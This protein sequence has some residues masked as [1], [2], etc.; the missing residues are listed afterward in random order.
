MTNYRQTMTQ[1]LEFMHIMN[2]F[3]INE[4]ELT[5]TE[6]KRREEIAQDM[7]DADFKS[8]YGDR[9]KEVKMAVATKQ[10]K[11]EDGDGPLSTVD[12]A[13]K[14]DIYHKTFSDAMQHSYK[15]AKKMYGITVDPKE[16]DQKV[17]AGPKKPS[18]GKTNRYQLKGDKGTIQVQVANLDN[19]KYE[20]NMYKEEVELDEDNMD[21]LRK[22][23][24]G[25]MQTIKFKDGKQ[26][27]DSFS[28]SGIMQVYDK[29][30]S[31]NKKAMEN[32]INKGTVSQV[33]KLQSLA[34]KQA[35]EEIKIE[36][37]FT[38]KDFDDKEDNN[39]HT[40]NAVEL[41]K[42]FGDNYEKRQVAQIQKDH[43]KNRSISAK[44][45]KVRDALI[46]KYLSKL[47]E[48]L[49]EKVRYSA[50]T[51]DGNTFQ[52][53]DRDTK[54]M[55]GKQDDYKMVVVD[56]KGKVV[57]DCGA[58]VTVDGA[59]MFAK[60][61]KIIED[62]DLDE[63]KKKTPVFK[64]TPAQIKKQM[65]DYK[66]KHDKLKIGEEDLDE[67]GP[68]LWANIHKKR[69][70]GRPMRKKGEKGAP[71]DAAIKRSQEEVDLDE[72]KETAQYTDGKQ[73]KITVTVDNMRKVNIDTVI[74]KNLRPGWKKV[75][76]KSGGVGRSI[77]DEVDLEEATEKDILNALKKERIGGY[78]S[79]GKLYVAQR[80]LETVRDLLRDMKLK[81]MPKLVG[82]ELSEFIKLGESG[83]ST[84]HQ[85]IK[86][87]KS[88]KEIA[89]LMKVDAKTIEKL[90][91]GF[92]EHQ[93]SVPHKHPHDSGDPKDQYD[94][95]EERQQSESARSDAMKSMRRSGEF[96]DKDDVDITAT[97]DDVK[98]ASKNIIMQMRKAQ[99]L[100]GR[101]AVE[102]LDR[103]KVKVP[104]KI[105]VAVQQKYNSLRRPAEKQKFQEKVAKSYKGMLSALKE[106]LEEGTWKVPETRI[107]QMALRKALRKPIKAKDAEKVM[108]PHIGDD[109]LYD[110]FYELEKDD[111]NQDVRPLIRNRMK[112]LGIKEETVLD[113]I[114]IK[115]QERK[116]G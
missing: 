94:D 35:K 71:T 96:S 64:G 103:K 92:K 44:D 76:K 98:A 59:V 16:I 65:K 49:D 19:K 87:G 113:R 34:M 61:K 73:E 85:H 51:K 24:K 21:L 15:A 2:E 33:L 99:S 22:A 82:E 27:M 54:G 70:E 93:T 50:K 56:K 107:D 90:M 105:A 18:A 43:N 42:M 109:S 106:A 101:F 7:D 26:K 9:W 81:V 97:D 41:V 6:K 84:L 45:Q 69:K 62:V 8:R 28:A 52:V 20:L 110:E 48:N 46:N 104:A 100:N 58:H 38:K 67:K 88:A 47:K 37:K 95:E 1:T 39:D 11:K 83:M 77:Y 17:A 57:K 36:E 68:G 86:D 53:I 114:A 5:D 63:Q 14:Y 116:N 25:A 10:A 23:A 102:F 72:K 3:R 60:N 4:R 40:Q 91:K 13:T 79:G 78:F 29:L 12:E 111:P 32:I 115:I 74:T 30:N 89:K 112:E 55:R 108:S 75:E 80:A 66:K 31:K